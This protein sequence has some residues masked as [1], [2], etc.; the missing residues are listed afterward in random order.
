MSSFSKN[1]Y[2]LKFRKNFPGPIK[3]RKGD[4]FWSKIKPV[5]F[6]M[7]ND[8]DVHKELYVCKIEPWHPLFR[9]LDKLYREHHND[10]WNGEFVFP[11]E[12]V[13][14]D[15]DLEDDMRAAHE[16]TVCEWKHKYDGG[17]HERDE[18]RREGGSG[19]DQFG[20]GSSERL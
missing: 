5:V 19:P 15:Q 1:E 6:R 7:A 12:F 9:K 8:P 20:D 4:V 14:F 3:F 16:A 2:L 17:D 10:D 13:E 18:S 11:C